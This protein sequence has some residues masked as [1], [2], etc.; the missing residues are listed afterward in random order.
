[1]AIFNLSEVFGLLKD[2]MGRA[3]GKKKERAVSDELVSSY[4]E[5][6]I[7]AGTRRSDFEVVL[8]DL[9][10]D[11]RLAAADIVSVALQYN[12]GGKKPASKAA[13][14]A[15]ISKRFVEIVRFHAK[16]KVAEKV[17]PW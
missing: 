14:L 8:A 3:Q 16:N 13:A 7:R 5:R 1:M 11:R 9:K 15:M 17:R 4:V 2:D 10:A 6:F 12:Q